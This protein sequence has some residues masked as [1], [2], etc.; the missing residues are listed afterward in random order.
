VNKKDHE[1]RELIKTPDLVVGIQNTEPKHLRQMW[2][3]KKNL[4]SSW[5]TE[6]E[7]YFLFGPCK[8]VMSRKCYWKEFSCEETA[9]VSPLNE[10]VAA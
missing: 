4:N 7:W 8:V 6:V 9:F 2:L 3:K 5:M 1:L 10:V